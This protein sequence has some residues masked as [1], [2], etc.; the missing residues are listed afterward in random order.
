VPATLLRTPSVLGGNLTAAALTASTSPAMITVALYVQDTLHLPPAQAGLL[1]PVF[2]LA[3]IGG[4]LLAPRGVRQIGVRRLLCT[5]FL[6]VAGGIALLIPLPLR[7]LPLSLLL[8]GF[9]VMG[10]GLGV[11][12]VASTTAGTAHV[13]DD[14]RGLAA[15]VLN[16]SAQLGTS[17]GLALA[18]P[19]VA[20][21]APMTGYRLGFGAAIVVALSGVAAAPAV[22]R[23]VRRTEPDRSLG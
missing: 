18:G 3:V 21:A 11:A 4:S 10:L 5:G 8:S 13:R 14:E 2:N 7:G 12:S 17:L 15:G 1:F 16:S 9:A 22:P 19:I 20:S 23:A 6:G